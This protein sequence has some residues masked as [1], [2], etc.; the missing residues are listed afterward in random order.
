MARRR[1][2]LTDRVERWRAR[3][4]TAARRAARRQAL[5][6]PASAVLHSP[7]EDIA[8]RRAAQRHYTVQ[9]RASMTPEEVAKEREANRLRMARYRANEPSAVAAAHLPSHRH[10]FATQHPATEAAHLAASRCH[11]AH[12]RDSR[13]PETAT[14]RLVATC[15]AH[16]LRAAHRQASRTLVKKARYVCVFSC[17]LT[18]PVLAPAIADNAPFPRVR[19]AESNRCIVPAIPYNFSHP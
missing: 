11:S 4:R 7:P 13:T 15:T 1:R 16:C 19:T 6:S 10:R 2:P 9:Y 14:A 18:Y 5:L 8:V 17:V 12:I 3:V